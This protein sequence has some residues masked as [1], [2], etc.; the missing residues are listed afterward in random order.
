MPTFTQSSPDDIADLSAQALSAAIHART[1]SCREVM[2]AYL[3]RIHRL[4]PDYNALIHLAADDDLLAQA[5]ARDAQL[6]RGESLGWMHGIPHAI[7]NT[8]H[9]LGFP[10]DFGC[11]LLQGVMPQHDQII[12]ERIKAAGA[13]IIGKTNIPEL[14][15]GSHT[16]NK[17]HGTTRNA[18]DLRVSAGGSSGGAAVAL[19][20]R[21]LPVADGSDFMGSLRNPAGWNNVFGMRP[22]QGI[23]P[24]WPRNEFWVHQLAIEGPMARNVRDLAQLL[25]TQA[26]PDSRDPMSLGTGDIMPERWPD[27]S[28]LKGLR[29][30]WLGNLNGHL[31]LE[32]GVLE[33]CEQ[34]LARMTS[35]GALVE[36]LS[37]GLGF[38]P[39]VVWKAWLVWRRALTAANVRGLIKLPHARELL[40]IKTLW[41]YD[42]AE[43]LLYTEFEMASEVRSTFYNAMLS[44]LS[45]FDVLALPVA[46]VW[47]FPAEQAWPTEIAGRTMDTYHRWMECTIYATMAGLPAVSVPA[48]FDASGRWPMGLQLIGQPRGDGALLKVAAAY[49]TIIE[50]LLDRR[51]PVSGL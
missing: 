13:I 16:F 37:S 30:G 5:D 39:Q 40:E 23:V 10:S 41:E 32:P 2:Q 11:P 28:S 43:G 21:M 12:A 8:A 7:K 42:Q 6:A 24:R 1:V 17:I 49:E 36:P 4:N 26:G 48:G 20:H 33:V 51:P 3:A 44:L 27:A 50:D 29:V 25:A 19:A 22:S 31:A 15:L 9:V 47:P 38:D 14:G 46:Q 34:G 18:W 45:R 35:A